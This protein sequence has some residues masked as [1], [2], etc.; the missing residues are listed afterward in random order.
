M[1]CFLFL[2]LRFF[3]DQG[4]AFSLIPRPLAAGQFIMSVSI[5]NY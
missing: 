4:Y 5:H 3:A 1:V 2:N